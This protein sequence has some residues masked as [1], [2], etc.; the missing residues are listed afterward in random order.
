M[1]SLPRNVRLLAWFNFFSDFRPYGPIAIL[2]FVQVSGSYALGMSVWSVASLAQSLFE[3]PTGVFSDMIGRKKT[4][5]CGAVAS[6]LSLFMYA[7]GG[8]YIALLAGGVFEG[9]ARAFYSG[10]NDAFL[11]DT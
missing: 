3:V 10:N 6:V 4:M 7:I 9:L 2:Y 1:Q 5:M 8:S 11:H